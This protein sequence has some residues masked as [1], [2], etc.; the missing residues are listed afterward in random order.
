MSGRERTA[1]LRKH[2]RTTQR[3]TKCKEVVQISGPHRSSCP[4]HGG[5]DGWMVGKGC[6]FL[7]TH[8]WAQLATVEETDALHNILAAE[9]A[10]V[11]GF[12][13]CLAAANV[14][15]FQEDHLGLGKEQ[16]CK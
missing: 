6:L 1:I 14:A 10:G 11:Q 12:G 15:T 3:H 4:Y 16:M 9:W 8:R 5:R 13:A 7:R 2:T